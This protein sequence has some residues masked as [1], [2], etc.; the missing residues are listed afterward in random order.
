MNVFFEIRKLLEFLYYQLFS[1][2]RKGHGIHS[3]FMFSLVRDVFSDR[4]QYPQ[5]NSL[6]ELRRELIK[7]QNILVY[8]DHGAGSRYTEQKGRTISQ[9]ARRAS[10]SHRYGRLIF[11]L[12]QRFKP[13]NMIEL[14]TGLG[15]GT[16]Y[17]ALS[18]P[19]SVVYTIE[20]SK[21]LVD[22]AKSNFKKIRAENIRV[23]EGEFQDGLD[24]LMKELDRFDFVYFDGNHRFGPT[25]HYFNL[26]ADKAHDNTIFLLD[27][28]RWSR[29]MEKAWQTIKGHDRVRVTVD[30]FQMGMVFFSKALSPQHFMVRY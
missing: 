27:D 15:L 8:E 12:G 1:K 30:L 6:M 25:V 2:S 23:I 11:L 29:E 3:P 16:C 9:M 7:N 10:T 28:I 14:G 19:Q 20:S 26:C 4:T 22:L 5:L 17:L 18:N 13:G 21:P 24:V